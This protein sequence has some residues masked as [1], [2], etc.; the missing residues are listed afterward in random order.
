M[1]LGV[2]KNLQKIQIHHVDL[3]DKRIAEVDDCILFFASF[4]DVS[5]KVR[6]FHLAVI[7]FEDNNSR[8]A[9]FLSERWLAFKTR[10]WLQFQPEMGDSV[11]FTA[12]IFANALSTR[13]AVVST[14]A[15]HL[16]QIEQFF[17]IPKEGL[18]A[19][20]TLWLF[21]PLNWP[22]ARS[23]Q[24]PEYNVI[25]LAQRGQPFPIVM[26]EALHAQ[27]GGSDKYIY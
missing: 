9:I 15:G 5:G 26:G 17:H 23:C 25:A 8:L 22:V 18:R 3:L 21:V 13:P 6:T 16:A 11:H 7:W 24:I 20:F 10:I 12:A 4:V 14:V 2:N 19:T 27:N 1:V